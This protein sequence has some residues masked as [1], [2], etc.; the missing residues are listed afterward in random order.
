MS[1]FISKQTFFFFF[2]SGLAQY[3]GILTELTVPILMKKNKCFW[4][5]WKLLSFQKNAWIPNSHWNW[6]ILSNNLK[7]CSAMTIFMLENYSGKY[8]ESFNGTEPS[9]HETT[10]IHPICSLTFQTTLAMSELSVTACPLLNSRS[11]PEGVIEAD[12]RPRLK[13]H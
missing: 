1:F 4:N 10:Y 8:T 13:V 3:I 7:F 11:S 2:W 5:Y 6:W 9:W 12:T